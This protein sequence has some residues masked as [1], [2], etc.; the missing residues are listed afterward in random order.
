MRP[1]EERLQENTCNR[2]QA[3]HHQGMRKAFD[4][5]LYFVADPA[6]CA[7]RDIASVT[8]SAVRGGA[9]MV[10]YRNKSGD[11]PII[12][13]EAAMLAELLKAEGVP[14]LVNDYVDVA[15]AARADGVHLGQ[16]DCAPM[17]AREKLGGQAIIGQT[18]FTP[19][20]MAAIDQSVIDYVGTGPFYETKTDKGKPVLGAKKFASLV[21][22]SPVPVVGIGGVTPQNARAVIDAGGAGVAFMRSVSEADDVEAAMVTMKEAVE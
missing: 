19:E 5:S 15:F 2:A 7:G 3:R 16:G 9:T 13:A 18:A 10:Q 20:H 8:M 14:F 4:L 6:C 1:Y 11:M 17:D 21:K 12:M 22:L